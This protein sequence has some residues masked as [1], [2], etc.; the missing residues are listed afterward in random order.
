MNKIKLAFFYLVMFFIC[1]LFLEIAS[2][3]ALATPLFYKRISQEG[4]LTPEP[5]WRMQWIQ[6]EKSMG[7]FETI[8]Q[9]DP[10]LGWALKPNLKN[11][12]YYKD[13]IINTNSKGIRSPQ[14]FTYERTT[15]KRRIL[16]I[17]DSY[18]MGMEASDNETL[19][20]YLQ[21]LMPD[22]EI[23]NMGVFGYG[24]DQMLLYWRQE[25]IKYHPDIV[26][27]GYMSCDDKRNMLGFRSYAKPR[28]VL[29]NDKLVLKN[30]PVPT[31]R[32]VL[33]RD[34]WR[35]RFVDLLQILYHNHLI[36]TGQYSKQSDRVTK[37][38]LSEFVKE[39][40]DSGAVPV[41]AYMEGIVTP[42]DPEVDKKFLEYWSPIVPTIYLVPYK[43]AADSKMLEEMHQQG[44]LYF[45]RKYDHFIPYENFVIAL[46]ITD[47]LKRMKLIQ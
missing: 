27:L 47:S 17:G 43:M 9:Y 22:A 23:I 7:Q 24:H 34:F 42:P 13:S 41:I 21:H 14:E 45:K 20:Y 25:G 29:Q 8:A 10:T 28:F 6:R 5:F 46:G 18:T 4:E 38:I 1:F 15:P 19:T 11:K 3:I 2:R 32:Q 44:P 40:K 36:R 30:E 12:V 31:P 35:S 26:I 33:Q 16:L 39:V 37:G